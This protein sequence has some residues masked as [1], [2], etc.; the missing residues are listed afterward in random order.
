[1]DREAMF[2]AAIAHQRAVFEDN[3]RPYSGPD[4]GTEGH[5]VL[6]GMPNSF[7]TMGVVREVKS[8]TRLGH[9]REGPNYKF[10]NGKRT[11]LRGYRRWGDK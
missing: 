4:L 7:P 5:K 2:L 1:M 3:L 8:D 10:I 11:K 9:R 6:G